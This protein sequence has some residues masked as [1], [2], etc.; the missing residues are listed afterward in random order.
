MKI[1]T[2][3]PSRGL[4]RNDVLKFSRI[5]EVKAIRLFAQMLRSRVG[6]PLFL[7]SMAR[8]L[9][10]SPVTLKKNLDVL[11]APCTAFVVRPWHDNIARAGG[12]PCTAQLPAGRHS[13]RG[14]T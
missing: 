2:N 1:A 4:V 5:Q 13:N 8:D 12:A 14:G 11:E 3:L 9:A 7:A 6:S 10:V